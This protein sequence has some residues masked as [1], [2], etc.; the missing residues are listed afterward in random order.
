VRGRLWPPGP[1]LCA[2][3]GSWYSQSGGHEYDV[4][5]DSN[6]EDWLENPDL[7]ILDDMRYVFAPCRVTVLASLSRTSSHQVTYRGPSRDGAA[8]ISNETLYWRDRLR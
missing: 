6:T 2:R 7:P 8:R 4:P 3:P 1:L 5:M